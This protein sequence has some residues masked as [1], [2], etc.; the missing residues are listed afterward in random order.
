MVEGRSGHHQDAASGLFSVEPCESRRW[1]APRSHAASK[2]AALLALVAGVALASP[3]PAAVIHVHLG[4]FFADPEVSVAA[5]GRSA[6]FVESAASALVLL[7]NVPGLGDPLVIVP[8]SGRTLSFGFAFDEG[9]GEDDAFFASL[10]AEFGG[11]L[12]AAFEFATDVTRSGTV[13]F[14][15][16]PL[17]GQTIGLQFELISNDSGPPAAGGSTLRIFDV[18]LIDAPVATAAEPT[19]AWL[20]CL[21]L[22]LLVLLTPIGAGRIRA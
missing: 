17:I 1:R 20:L 12:G 19:V 13:S 21:P 2:I 3:V 16:A 11:S 6:T 18:R 15:L 22:L 7:S 10:Q 8:A 14:D 4:D 5:D 9:A